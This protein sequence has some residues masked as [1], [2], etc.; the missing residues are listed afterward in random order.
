MNTTLYDAPWKSS[1][2]L[3]H[4]PVLQHWRYRRSFGFSLMEG[5]ERYELNRRGGQALREFV[6]RVF[7]DAEVVRKVSRRCHFSALSTR[8]HLDIGLFPPAYT[9]GEVDALHRELLEIVMDPLNVQETA[10]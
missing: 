6:D 5:E 8:R 1:A 4:L 7:H 10:R 2:A 3:P 9:K